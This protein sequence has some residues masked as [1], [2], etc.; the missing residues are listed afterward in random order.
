MSTYDVTSYKHDVENFISDLAKLAAIRDN[1]R[2]N[3]ELMFSRLQ[4][5]NSISRGLSA[6]TAFLRYMEL[7][8]VETDLA[9]EQRRHALTPVIERVSYAAR[10]LNYLHHGKTIARPVEL[11]RETYGDFYGPDFFEFIPFAVIDNAVKYK[12]RDGDIKIKTHDSGIDGFVDISSFGPAI[13]EDERE[14]IFQ[15]GSR[16][17]FAIEAGRV[18]SGIGLYHARE[19]MRSA[20]GG[21]L[22][23]VR[24]DQSNRFNVDGVPYDYHTFRLKVP[25]IV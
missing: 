14:R 24:S 6:K 21:D 10:Q 16:G 9:I 3:A 15:Q 1:E 13:L 22:L 8:E 12:L 18:G 17:K 25:L 2:N 20:F 4:A 19:A 23:L 11:V 5:I 7:S